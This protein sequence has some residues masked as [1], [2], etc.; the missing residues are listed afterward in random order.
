MD[1][2]QDHFLR[3][4]YAASSEAVIFTDT[5]AV[6]LEVNEATRV[7]YGFSDADIV[8]HHVSRIYTHYSEYES[9]LNRGFNFETPTTIEDTTF[10]YR[11][12]DGTE[13]P[14]QLTGC[15]V[16]DG[17]GRHCGYIGV[18]R[19]VTLLVEAERQRAALKKAIDAALDSIAE[20][21]AIFDPQE[22]LILY[23]R[24]FRDMC[25]E[26]KSA[27]VTG[28]TL[29]GLLRANLAA[30]TY[31]GLVDGTPEAEEWLQTRLRDHRKPIDGAVVFPYG[32]GRWMRSESRVT[33]SG[34]IV[35][36]RIDI[37]EIKR[38]E[39]ALQGKQ[40]EYYSLLQNMPDLI[41]RFAADRTV[42][43]VNENY[44][45]F[46]ETTSDAL[47]GEDLLDH[48]PAEA[49]DVTIQALAR[50]RPDAPVSN[51]ETLHHKSNGDTAWIYWTLLGIF[52]RDRLVEFVSV[53]RDI[54][55]LKRQQAQVAEQTVELQQKN[56]ALNQFTAT[57]SHDL[58]APLRHIA[59]FSE[60]IADD[61][62]HGRME[63]LPA[64]ADH[65]RRATIRMQRLV[66][67]LLDYSQIAYQ[68][69]TVRPVSLKD[70]VA[71]TLM[72][73]ETQI[74]ECKAEIE[75]GDLPTVAGD[76][77]LLKRLAQ[78]LLSNA[79]KYHRPGE[80][81][82]IRI[83]GTTADGGVNFVVED[84]GIGIDP[85]YAQK[86][87]DVFQRLHRDESVYQGTGIGLA[88]AKRIAESHGGSIALDTAY[89][90]GARFVVT[91]PEPVAPPTR[92]T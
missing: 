13:F 78:N 34:H 83:Y 91:F 10:R 12:K 80:V 59:M 36:L 62:R 4:L 22:R 84:K 60:M 37:T 74:I 6:V 40:R 75:V 7:L 45:R 65:V 27:V 28:A 33:D 23:N 47:I 44:A 88:L 11:R 5:D 76:I 71:E 21:F 56:E 26:A 43:F 46:F 2:V 31:P 38:V 69:A 92:I 8:G 17:E 29:E 14:G 79:L 35:G 66:E 64:N 53:G 61:V 81:P 16:M 73:L 32:D 30:G 54:T 68:I 24:A 67:S 77:E 52:D 42:L 55:E 86:I 50:F 49:H 72:L 58:K 1:Y 15:R 18:I 9:A 70:V 85:R 3:A 20:G 89:R 51:R 48:V 19:D 57:V 87:F 39:L 63:E 90:H 41:C 82:R 25:G